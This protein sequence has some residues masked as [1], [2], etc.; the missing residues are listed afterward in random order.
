MP[1]FHSFSRVIELYAFRCH[2]KSF[3]AYQVNEINPKHKHLR[4]ARGAEALL[5]RMQYFHQIGINQNAKPDKIS[6]NTVIIAWAKSDEKGSAQ[7]AENLLK[8]TLS[9]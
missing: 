2:S 5:R 9:T 4:P 3:D 7:S 8:Y 6:Y 1:S